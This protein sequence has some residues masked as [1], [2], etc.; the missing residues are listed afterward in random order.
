[1]TMVLHPTR[2]EAPRPRPTSSQATATT[3]T[4]APHGSDDRAGRATQGA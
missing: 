2:R 3:K 1:M 4:A